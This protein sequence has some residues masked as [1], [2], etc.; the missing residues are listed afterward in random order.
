LDESVMEITMTTTS[1]PIRFVPG[2][3]VFVTFRS[4]TMSRQLHPLSIILQGQSAL[5]ALRAGEVRKQFHPFSITSSSRED[6]LSVAVKAVGDYTRA[7]RSLEQG[8]E[9]LVEGP[10]GAFSYEKIDNKKQVWVA[11]GIGITPFLSMARSL[12]SD[13]YEVDLYYCTRPGDAAYF[14][15]EL[16]DI[17]DRHLRLRVIH[18]RKDF[19]GRLT[20]KDIEG[21]SGGLVDKDI[22]IC[23]PPGM[24]ENLRAGFIDR[25]VPRARI[26]F[27]RFRFGP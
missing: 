18:I 3:F 8:A 21:A 16:F 5:I 15:D 26:H 25:G 24:V 27:E 13:A 9:V 23:G 7:M 1:A 22:L 11:G 14:I 10:Y 2:Q 6:H 4:E 12:E 19:I 20:T 17:A